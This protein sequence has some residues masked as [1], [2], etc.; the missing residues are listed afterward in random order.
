V[1]PVKDFAGFNPGKT[2][3]LPFAY[4]YFPV[5]GTKVTCEDGTRCPVS[6]SQKENFIMQSPGVS[7]RSISGR[8]A[9]PVL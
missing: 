7:M 3:G 6:V 2:R 4:E 8:I 1:G 9:D 5:V